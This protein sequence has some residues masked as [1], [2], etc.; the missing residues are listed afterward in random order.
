MR[1]SENSIVVFY[2]THSTKENAVQFINQ[3]LDEKWIAC[4]NVFK[5]DSCYEWQGSTVNE[6]EFVSIVK[7]AP[8]LLNAFL[9]YAEEIHPYDVPCLVHWMA[10][11]NESY[12]KWVKDNVKQAEE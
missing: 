12:A 10:E 2:I 8:R 5:I 4:G 9:Q 3:C 11:A 6:D 7:T 1:R